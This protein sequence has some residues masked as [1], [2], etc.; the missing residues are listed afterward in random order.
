MKRIH[1]WSERVLCEQGKKSK[2]DAGGFFNKP[3]MSLD[4]VDELRRHHDRMSVR[5]YSLRGRAGENIQRDPL[6]SREG[7][8]HLEGTPAFS[9]F[10]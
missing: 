2:K 9:T 7:P 3:N 4:H 10:L 6:A 1:A 5:Q 8:G